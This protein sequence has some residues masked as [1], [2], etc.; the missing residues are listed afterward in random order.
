VPH[1]RDEYIYQLG[2]IVAG[3]AQ[4]AGPGHLLDVPGRLQG[5]HPPGADL[6]DGAQSK[7]SEGAKATG[8]ADTINLQVAHRNLRVGIQ[9]SLK[10]P[11][12]INVPDLTGVAHVAAVRTLGEFVPQIGES[13]VSTISLKQPVNPVLPSP[14]ALVAHEAH[15]LLFG[16]SFTE[17]IGTVRHRHNQLSRRSARSICAVALSTSASLP[18]VAAMSASSAA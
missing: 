10:D 17:R 12:S 11:R 5:R 16:R 4:P 6:L 18:V 2:I 7:N 8:G 3:L 1:P 9:S 13:D 15:H 14:A